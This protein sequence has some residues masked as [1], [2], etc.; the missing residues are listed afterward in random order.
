MTQDEPPHKI[1]MSTSLPIHDAAIPHSKQAYMCHLCCPEL[2][3][4]HCF[5]EGVYST[6][7]DRYRAY[8]NTYVPPVATS[9]TREHALRRSLCQPVWLQQLDNSDT[10]THT[11]NI[12]LNNTHSAFPNNSRNHSIWSVFGPNCLGCVAVLIFFGSLC[13]Q[14]VRRIYPKFISVCASGLI[15]LSCV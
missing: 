12:P 2:A 11:Q 15:M 10:H 5:I 3:T 4:T 6:W 8:I 14:S 13:T 1:F 9:E 7:S